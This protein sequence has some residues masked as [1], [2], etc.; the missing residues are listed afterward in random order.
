MTHMSR[1][2][3][4]AAQ[5]SVRSHESRM[6]RTT[7]TFDWRLMSPIPK[8]ALTETCVVETGKP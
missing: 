6:S 2:P 5:G 3:L 7:R 4:I 1:P 8:R